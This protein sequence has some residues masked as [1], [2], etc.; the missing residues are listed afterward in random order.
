MAAASG[1]AVVLVAHGSPEARA[2]EEFL[3]LAAALQTRRPDWKVTAGFLE[4]AKPDVLEMLRDALAAG[5][6]PVV[7]LPCFLFPGGHTGE[8]LPR[9]VDQATR[10]TDGAVVKVGG[11]LGEHPAL[12]DILADQIPVDALND[13]QAKLV[14]VAAGSVAL[15]NR[16]ALD[17]F[18]GVIRRKTGLGVRFAYLDQGEPQLDRVLT[19]LAAERAKQVVILP[20]LLFPG[21]YERTL[22]R[23]VDGFRMQ[24]TGVNLRVGGLLGGDPRLAAIL[25][26]QAVELLKPGRTA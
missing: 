2:N 24:R 15:A 5:G 20:C 17:R 23:I 11:T 13:A 16:E 22:G 10:G 25:E 19:D 21:V 4:R 12:A 26:A 3:N 8:D 18:A 14:L 6:A 1:P 7:L 9:L